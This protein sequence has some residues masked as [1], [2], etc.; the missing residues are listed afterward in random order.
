MTN[1]ILRLYKEYFEKPRT[2]NVCHEYDNHIDIDYMVIIAGD[3]ND[4]K[5]Y[6]LACLANCPYC[7]TVSIK[8][9]LT[10]SQKE[11]Y[12]LKSKMEKMGGLE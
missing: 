12:I 7:E 8:F 9:S 6:K 3:G 5:S 4:K 2:C 10:M 1:K 11:A